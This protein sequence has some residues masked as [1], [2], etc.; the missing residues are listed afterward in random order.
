[1]SLLDKLEDHF[2]R[3][4]RSMALEVMKLERLGRV[5][6]RSDNGFV[7]DVRPVGC[8]GGRSAIFTVKTLLGPELCFRFAQ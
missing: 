2:R 8:F 3:Y 7:L 5:D 1:M 6:S 4:C